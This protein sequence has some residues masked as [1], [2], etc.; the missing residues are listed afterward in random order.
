MPS[1]PPSFSF[2]HDNSMDRAVDFV[3]RSLYCCEMAFIEAFKPAQADA[4][5]DLVLAEN[6][7]FLSALLRHMQMSNMLGACE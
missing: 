5:M 4:K 1:I 3:R 2:S 7:P 6:R